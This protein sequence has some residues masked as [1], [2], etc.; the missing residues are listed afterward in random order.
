MVWQNVREM[1]ALLKLE[2][3]C[4]TLFVLYVSLCTFVCTHIL[5]GKSLSVWKSAQRFTSVCK[6]QLGMS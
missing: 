1:Y 3:A 5:L 6:V 4:R 2:N